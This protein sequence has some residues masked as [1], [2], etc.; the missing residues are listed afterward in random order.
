MYQ[1]MKNTNKNKSKKGGFTYLEVVFS[2]PLL[3]LSVLVAATAILSSLNY[4]DTARLKNKAVNVGIWRMEQ[5][6]T[7]AVS[8]NNFNTRM[9]AYNGVKYPATEEGKSQ[10]RTLGIE[11]PDDIEI[12][13]RVSITQADLADVTVTVCYRGRS[14]R[15]MGED[16]D[17][18]GVLSGAE[19]IN[20]N[21][22]I[23]SPI[24]FHTLVA[25]K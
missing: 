25:R 11:N 10:L 2:L 24:N 15:V 1:R 18:D 20:Q 7:E 8:A 22:L 6:R 19:D 14:G 13:S 12:L 17:L 5:I 3:L 16:Q 4:N 9:L 21:G 23:D